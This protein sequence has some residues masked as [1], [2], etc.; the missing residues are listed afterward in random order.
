MSK[1]LDHLD[2]IEEKYKDISTSNLISKR[3]ELG[4]EIRELEN[5]IRTLNEQISAKQFEYDDV[6]DILDRRVNRS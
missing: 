2:M 4:K 1:Y 6:D 5:Q 3:K